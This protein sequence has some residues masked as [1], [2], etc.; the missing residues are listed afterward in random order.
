MRFARLAGVADP[1]FINFRKVV[2]LKNLLNWIHRKY[3]SPLFN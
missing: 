3:G 2:L 1:S